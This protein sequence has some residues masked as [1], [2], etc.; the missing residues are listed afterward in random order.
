VTEPIALVAENIK[1][2]FPRSGFVLDVERIE[3]QAGKVLALLGPSGSGKTTLMHILGLLERP[4][5]GRVLL[6]GREV[7][8]RDRDA[9]LQIAAV[10]QRPYLFK[11][12]VAANVAYGLTVRGVRGA[13]RERLV[14]AALERVGLVGYE[15]RSALALSGGEAQ[16]VSLARALVLEPRVL[17]LDEPLASLDPLLK[18]HLTHDFARIL[19]E[20]GATAVWVTHDQ[21]EALVVADYVTVMNEGRIIAAGPTDDVMGLPADEWTASFLGMEEP[22]IGTVAASDNGLVEI[23]YGGARIVVTGDAPVGSAVSFAVRPED[24][25]LFEDGAELPLSTARNQMAALVESVQG[26]G[27]INR[28]VLRV[29]DMRLAASVSRSSSADLGLE[30]GTRVLA[31]FKATA[32]RW[33]ESA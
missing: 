28:I 12:A 19:R 17:L 5:S 11:G 23:E 4:D 20:S 32:V 13:E 8:S 7:T 26:R 3:A 16:R 30:P 22:Q 2:T 21:D 9:R 18:R 1:R 27:T 33:R 6:G 24:V 29:G 25:L 14:A 10:F 15:D 31:V